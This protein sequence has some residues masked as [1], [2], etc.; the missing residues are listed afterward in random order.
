MTWDTF[1]REFLI[2]LPAR[3]VSRLLGRLRGPGIG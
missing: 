1:M 2:K 3:A